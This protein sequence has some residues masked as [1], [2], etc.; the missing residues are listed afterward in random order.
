MRKKS[1]IKQIEKKNH[2]LIS[3]ISYLTWLP[4]LFQ[5]E[6]NVLIDIHEQQLITQGM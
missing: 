4:V 1:A 3:V 5:V 2:L 6:I